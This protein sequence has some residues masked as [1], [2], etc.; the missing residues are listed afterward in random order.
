M[1]LIPYT[2]CLFLMLAS[3]TA[4]TT[5][6]NIQVEIGGTKIDVQALDG[7][8]EISSISPKALKLF[9]TLTPPTNRLLA[10]FVSEKDLNKIKNDENLNLKRYMILQVYK[11]SENKY[12]SENEFTPFKT[13]IKNQH[14]NL[15]KYSK[16]KIKSLLKDASKKLSNDYDIPLKINIGEQVPLSIFLEHPSAIGFTTLSKYQTAVK[17]NKI[18]TTVA[19]STLFVKVKNKL[20]YAYVYSDYETQEDI[21]WVNSQSKSWVE[22]IIASNKT[23]TKEEQAYENSSKISLDN[24]NVTSG[25]IK[26][27]IAG[28][29]IALIILLINLFIKRKNNSK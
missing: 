7:F 25:Y 1:Q 12:I 6:N 24:D 18:D 26:G 9:D 22:S 13:L 17:G 2:M 4:N 15:L 8:Y 3:G 19:Y 27:A 20:I 28:F 5:Q 14:E 29:S 10:V 21:D 16:D 11:T 23:S